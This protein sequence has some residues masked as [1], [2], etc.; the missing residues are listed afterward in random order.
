VSSPAPVVR[1]CGADDAPSLRSIR[2]EALAD[3]PEAYGSTYAEARRWSIDRWE[4]MSRDWNFY[5]AEY[6][7]RVVGMASG[8]LNDQRPG[9][10]WLYGM[11]VAPD[12][13]GTGVAGQ[14]VG[15]VEQWARGEGVSSLYLHVTEKLARAR[16]FYERIGFRSTGDV[17]AMGRDPSLRLVTM[18][19]NLE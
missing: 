5:L 19:K 12:M 10:R 14:L 13:R 9:T 2:L 15:V 7:G 16:G 4:T 11:Y 6:Q 1:P 3:T 17:I 8:G 18:V